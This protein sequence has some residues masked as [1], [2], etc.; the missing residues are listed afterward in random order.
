MVRQMTDLS[1]YKIVG[2]A[3][4]YL[5]NSIEVLDDLR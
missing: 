5:G 2:D 3:S 1:P 4:L